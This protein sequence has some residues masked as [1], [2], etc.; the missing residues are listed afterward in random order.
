MK[1]NWQ[2]KVFILVMAISLI[3]CK[4]VTG[5][6][7]DDIAVASP[8]EGVPQNSIPDEKLPDVAGQEE[9]CFEG[10]SYHPESE[11]CYRDDGSAEAPFQA[12]MA[13][14]TDYSDEDYVDVEEGAEEVSLV[15]YVITGNDISA[16]E[17]EDVAN[18][19]LD[20][21]KDTA[22]HQKIWDYFSAIIPADSRS[23]VSNY[24][25]FTDGK[26]GT[27]AAVE[28]TFHDPYAWMIEI[29]I[30]DT[31]DMQE[32]TFTLIHEFG[33]LLTL[34]SEQ[35]I[36]NEKVFNN[37]EDED[38]YF[39]A[40]ENC[41]TYFTGEGC[42]KPSS[43]FN[44]FIDEFWEDIYD[45]WNSIQGMDDDD[46]YYEA[47]DNFYF[48]HEDQFLTDYAVTNPGEDIAETWAFFV[49]QPKPAGN[50]IAEKKV[51]FFYEFPE[52]VELRNEIIARSY[53]R[54]IRMQ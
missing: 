34:N 3:A 35:V 50:T 7:D 20:E 54:L 21:Q 5:P 46:E 38:I 39:E 26:N 17:Y 42:A 29:D 52:L 31:E 36:V 47:L 53:S 24:V 9:T 49:T 1:K 27:L 11:I 33:H 41:A 14:V 6:S 25:V 15:K 43:Y 18:D 8:Q 12:M 45:E 37:Y 4:T 10:E 19:L 28:Q 23:F 44:L 51:L 48:D 16:P 40:E 22:A 32:L 13:G 30:A 2:I